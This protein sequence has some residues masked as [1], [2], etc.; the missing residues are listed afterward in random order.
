MSLARAQE[1][2]HVGGRAISLGGLALG[3]HRIDVGDQQEELVAVGIA[4]HDA[5]GRGANVVLDD[6]VLLG[7]LLEQLDEAGIEEEARLLQRHRAV[8]GRGNLGKVFVLQALDLAPQGVSHALILLLQEAIDD[9][10]VEGGDRRLEA[11]LAGEQDC[12]DRQIADGAAELDARHL[13]HVEVDDGH[14]D[15]LLAGAV[16]DHRAQLRQLQAQEAVAEAHLRAEVHVGDVSE[17]AGEIGVLAGLRAK[18]LERGI[19]TRKRL[20]RHFFAKLKIQTF[21]EKA[22]RHPERGS[23]S[24]GRKASYTCEP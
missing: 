17:V 15:A 13:G 10:L 7:D 19:R 22:D 23:R 1:L 8:D 2:N 21:S 14:G 11:G 4:H 5:G 16:L 20:A 9:T 3:F 24:D 6:V 18:M 12:L